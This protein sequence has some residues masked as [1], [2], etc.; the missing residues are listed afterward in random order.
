[1]KRSW[2]VLMVKLQ[3]HCRE[4]A[5]CDKTSRQEDAVSVSSYRAWPH[6]W[7]GCTCSLT[8]CS[9]AVLPLVKAWSVVKV[10]ELLDVGRER[11][12]GEGM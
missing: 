1:M 9:L 10:G 6:W 4:D 11:R 3:D 12:G 5:C 8:V 7:R 2:Y